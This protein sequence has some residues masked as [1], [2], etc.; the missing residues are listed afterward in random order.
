MTQRADISIHRRLRRTV[1]LVL[2]VATVLVIVANLLSVTFANKLVA[3][4]F[5]VEN[6]VWKGAVL[7]AQNPAPE[8]VI[9]GSS[10]VQNHFNTDYFNAR[11]HKTFN[12]GMPGILPWDFPSMV[13]HAAQVATRTVVISVPAEVL[14]FPA[15]GCPN[16]WTMTDILF[17]AKHVPS[18]LRGLSLVQWLQ[19]L[20]INALFRETFTDVHHYPC[21][22]EAGDRWLD[23]VAVLRES[24]LCSDPRKLMLVR[25]SRRWVAVFSNGDGLIVPDD[26]PPR[27]AQVIW[28]DKR[29]MPLNRDVIDFLHAL[30]G[31]VRDAGKTPVFMIE[32]SPVEHLMIDHVL[33]ELTGVRSLYM[34]EISFSD[35]EI[36]DH[37]HLGIRGNDRLTKLLFDQLVNEPGS[38]DAALQADTRAQ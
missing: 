31:L 5:W 12:L 37:D 13:Q 11:G 34:N 21:E 38:A 16:Q 26:Y 1:G 10:R 24:N 8:W 9:V 20:P 32:A 23:K 22:G 15:V 6:K 19:P 29:G 25:Y 2:V 4:G 27:Q 36:A 28:N 33:E 3:Q 17:Y 30:A 18:C 7:D 14:F 35:D